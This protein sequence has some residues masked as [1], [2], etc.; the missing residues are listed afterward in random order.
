[1][2]PKAQLWFVLPSYNFFIL[3]II[4]RIWKIFTFLYA[5]WKSLIPRLRGSQY[6]EIQILWEEKQQHQNQKKAISKNQSKNTKNRTKS[7]NTKGKRSKKKKQ[8]EN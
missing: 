3:A 6:A 5:I 4:S 7:K 1:L 8:M 2:Y